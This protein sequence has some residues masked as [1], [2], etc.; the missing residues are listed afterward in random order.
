ML[1]EKNYA[2]TVE[3]ADPDNYCAGPEQYLL[4]FLNRHVAGFCRGG[5]FVVRVLRIVQRSRLRFQDSN[6]SGRGYVHVLFRAEVSV[7]AM[8]DIL[9]GVVIAARTQ[10][11]VGRSEAEGSA[12]VSLH[13]SA[14]GGGSREEAVREGQTVAVRVLRTQYSPG[15]PQASVAGYL[16]TCDRAA[17]V[18]ALEGALSAGDGAALAGLAQRAREL[19]EARAA[20]AAARPDDVAFF[21]TLLY[22]YPRPPDGGPPARAESADAP[23]WAGPP[24][25]PLPAGAEAANL[26]D[27]VDRA[28]AGGVDVSGLWSRDLALHRTAP[29]AAR[30]AAARPPAGWTEAVARNPREAFAAMLASVVSFL[31]AVSAMVA[32]FSSPEKVADHKNV[33]LAM[34]SAQ[35]PPPAAR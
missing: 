30:A 8:W 9:P 28:R 18:F 17:P 31:G 23:A 35:L 20:L 25:Y 16:L 12:I 15:Q 10:M 32:D 6:L 19:L 14:S 27:L 11:I 24:A 29:L 4:V 5:A 21:D 34:R 1:L 26:L 33:W 22:S 13:P 2:E 7:F 3:I